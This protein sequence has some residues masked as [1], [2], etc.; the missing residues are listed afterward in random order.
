[1]RWLLISII[2]VS[3]NIRKIGA[4][5]DTITSKQASDCYDPY[6]RPQVSI[7]SYDFY[8]LIKISVVKLL[9]MVKFSIFSAWLHDWCD[10][11]KRSHIL[12]SS[13]TS[14]INNHLNTNCQFKNKEPCINCH[15]L[16]FFCSYKNLSNSNSCHSYDIYFR[17]IVRTFHV[18]VYEWIF[19]YKFASKLRAKIK[20]FLSFVPD[21]KI[22]FFYLI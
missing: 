19:L 15:D 2:L 10:S 11:S 12:P 14:S 22:C 7:I 6:G 8:S 4:N 1:M 17:T 9:D 20:I 5:S 13:S 3:N 16:T 21:K 18:Y